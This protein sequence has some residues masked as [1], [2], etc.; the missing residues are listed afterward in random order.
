[1]TPTR[2]S[3]T[4]IPTYE[5][6]CLACHASASPQADKTSSTPIAAEASSP[7]CAELPRQP[8]RAMY[9]LSHAE[10]R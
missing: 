6:K 7:Q 10:G 1:M 3:I 8:D 9:L 5:A 2:S 4:S